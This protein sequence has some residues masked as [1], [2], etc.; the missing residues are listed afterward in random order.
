MAQLLS[1]IGLIYRLVQ[2]ET[3]RGATGKIE[4]D[5]PPPNCNPKLDTFWSSLQ[6]GEFGSCNQLGGGDPKCRGK[7][8]TECQKDYQ[9]F[10]NARHGVGSSA[11]VASRAFFGGSFL[12]FVC[13]ICRL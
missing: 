4:H 5:I 12:A 1:S 11:G 3:P 2:V 13:S 8:G 9:G 7:H 10:P 6:S